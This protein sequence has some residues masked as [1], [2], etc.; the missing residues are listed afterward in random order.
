MEFV[1]LDIHGAELL[2]GDPLAELPEERMLVAEIE[3]TTKQLEARPGTWR[4]KA[5]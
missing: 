3:K 4:R 1:S 5:R 2:R